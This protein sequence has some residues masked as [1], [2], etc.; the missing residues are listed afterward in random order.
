[1]EGAISAEEAKMAQEASVIP[2][3]RPGAG[4]QKPVVAVILEDG[5]VR[6]VDGTD[7][8]EGSGWTSGQISGDEWVIW[9]QRRSF[10]PR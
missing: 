9:W 10:G 8:N 2:F 3:R 5:S 7:A 1:M 6:R 4:P